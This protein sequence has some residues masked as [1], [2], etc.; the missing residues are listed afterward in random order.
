MNYRI[1]PALLPVL[2]AVVCLGLGPGVGA[3]EAP[4]PP[5]DAPALPLLIVPTDARLHYE[6]RFDTRDAAGPRCQWPTSAVTLRFQGSDLNARLAEQGQDRWQVA[7][8]GKPVTVLTLQS[9]P[10]IYRV[11]SGLPAGD[12]T[13][14]LTKRT[15]SFF[16]TTQ[17]LGFQL[18]RGGKLLPVTV[19]KH[20]LEVIGD[21]IS[22]GYG[23]EAASQT[24]HFKPETENAYMTYG[25]IA[26]RTLGA[27]YVCIAW[28]GKKMWPDNTMGELYDRTLPTDPSSQWDF[29][30][31]TP[32]VILINLATNDFNGKNPDEAGWTGGYE[33][34]I[35][36]LRKLYPKAEIY[37]ATSPMMGDWG[38]NKPRT[39][40]QGYLT[41]IVSDE[42]AAGDK[43]VHFIEFAVQDAKNGIGADWH[44]SVKTHELMAAKLAETLHTDLGW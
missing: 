18:S 39:T 14:S 40:V 30:K 9:G 37:C 12:H 5:A 29:A 17:I 24:E 25:A 31:W 41:K 8:D 23:N 33:A 38:K 19:P 15:E 42:R 27:D 26:A 10:H 7:L 44:P 35:A 11:A 34:F 21:S 16:G 36:R 28:S 22:C 2:L 3:D 32:D 1:F 13:L 6:G 20:R 4:T 43:K